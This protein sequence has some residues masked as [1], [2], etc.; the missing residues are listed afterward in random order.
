MLRNW[1]GICD[2]MKYVIF[3]GD[4]MADYPVEELGGRT[5]LQA[6]KTPMMDYI[7]SHGVLGLVKTVPDG[8]APGSDVA[9]L[10]VM[11][12]NPM[13]C[14]TG[15]SPLEAASVGVEMKPN[16]VSFRCNLVTLSDAECYEDKVMVDYSSDEITTSEA[17]ELIKAVN[18]H[19]SNESLSFY[20]GISYRHLLLWHG[21]DFNFSLTPPHDISG[22]KI[23]EYLPNNPTLL[24]M[25]QESCS[26]LSKHPINQ[27]REAKGL[28]PANAIWIWGQGTKPKLPAFYEKYHLKAS[29]ISA[30][31]LI[32][33]IALC[34]GMRSVDVEGTTGNV[35]TNFA[36][37][38]E[39]AIEE[40]KN[41]QDFV[42]IHVEA[43]DESGHRNEL[44]N[45][46][47]SIERIDEKIMR[48]VMDYLK[49]CGEDYKVMVLPDHPT[50]LALR[51]HTSDPVPFAL[52]DSRCPQYSAI[53]YSEDNAKN[54][55]LYIE[56]GF[57][58]MDRFIHSI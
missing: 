24:S 44:D 39:A 36:G 47:K 49:S 51:T 57:T 53:T 15:R 56:D 52:Y 2:S 28:H 35:H 14:Y 25:M 40:L 8:I 3:L 17:S 18:Q 12:F 20:A 43:A 33:G 37:K 21:I 5:P 45:K 13:E 1:K 58:L 6:A 19:F 46:V 27:Q 7:A 48:P 4:G 32:K 11:G 10:S 30:V 54:S 9:N 42:Y 16:D 23:G 22:R 26:F 38:A 31:D 41:G 29:V 55:S 34:A 50:P